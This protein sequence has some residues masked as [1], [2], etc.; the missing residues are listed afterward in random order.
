LH[1]APHN[2]IS[3]GKVLRSHVLKGQNRAAQ[4][5]RLAAQ[6]VSKTDTA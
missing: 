4:A 1:L 3:G 6:A 5:F 2:D